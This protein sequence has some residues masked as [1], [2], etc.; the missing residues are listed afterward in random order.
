MPYP[1]SPVR[2]SSLRGPVLHVRDAMQQAVGARAQ[3]EHLDLDAR[4]LETIDLLTN[5]AAEHLA[6]AHRSPGKNRVYLWGPP[7]RGKTWLLGAFFDALPTKRKLRVHFH[8]FFRDLHA[9]AHKATT[10]ALA[11]IDEPDSLGETRGRA[12]RVEARTSAIEQ[13]I[14]S[15]LGDVQVLCFDEFHCNDPGDAMLLAR[16]VKYI[17]D[18]GILLVTT[19]NYP[20]EELLSDEYYHHLVLPTIT[21]IREHMTVH[22]LDAHL[23]YR[24][25]ERHEG[26]R[27]GFSSGSLLHSPD[28]GQLQRLG[29]A[30]PDR[31]DTVRLTPTSHEIRALRIDGRQIWFGFADLCE[32]L[33]S[34]LDY[35]KLVR[36]HDHWIISGVPGS[37][38]MTPFGLR[39]LAN[40]IDV[41]Y[42]HQVRLDLFVEDGFVDSFG[43]LP[44]LE[45]ARLRSR[46][47]ALRSGLEPSGGKTTSLEGVHA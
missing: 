17:M 31:G 9:T 18:R 11:Q 41:L 12:D 3:S 33:T 37:G 14:E 7:G 47:N 25:I 5:N 35:L 21:T 19:S 15:M 13:S 36:D 40:V 42:D 39:R 26:Q 28:A 10:L 20:P 2:G 38:L 4:Q 29:L 30:E 24:T 32:S 46:V 44:E 8:D 43:H 6:P 16:T 27:S 23:D 22:E 1:K 45:A 34:T